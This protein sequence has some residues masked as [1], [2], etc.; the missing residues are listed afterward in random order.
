MSESVLVIKREYIEHFIR[1][2]NGLISGCGAELMNII[3]AKHTFI[4]RPEAERDPSYKQ[5]IPY[6]TLCRD[7]QVFATRRLSQG[8]ESRLHGL[9]SLGVGGHI[10]P[11][12]DD[13]ASPLMN[14]LRRE[15]A[16]EVRIERAGALVPRGVINDDT[17]EVGSVHL[18]F[19]FTLDVEGEV[20]VRETEKLSGEWL[21]LSDLCGLKGQME[22]WSQLIVEALI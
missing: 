6:V 7:D 22:T 1:E 20:T 15:V 5:I 9:L 14:G 2:K 16:E 19:F 13:A 18:G 21:R 10:N 3:D 8:G 4:P 17:N 12:D 11:A